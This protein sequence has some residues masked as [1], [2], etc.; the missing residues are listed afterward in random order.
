MWLASLGVSEC[1]AQRA[2]RPAASKPKP[3]LANL[4]YGP[5]PRNVLDLWRASSDRPT[6]L[7]VF[8]HGGGFR[9]GSKDEKLPPLLLEGCLK[10]GISVMAINYRLTP[11]VV[12]PAHYLDCARAIQFARLHAREWNLD[13]SRIAASGGSAGAITSLWLGFHDDMADPTSPDPVLRQSTRLTCM[14]VMYAQS[15]FDPRTIREWIG[16]AAAQDPVL[17]SFYGLKDEEVNTP[18]AFQLY[19]AAAPINRL[20]KD[21]PPVYA[22]YL[23]ARGPLPPNAKPGQGIHHI[24]FGLRLK[25]KMDHLGIECIV[26]HRDEGAASEQE[27]VEFLKRHLKPANSASARTAPA[28]PAVELS[29]AGQARLPV[30]IA[31]DASPEVKA[32]ATELTAGL[33]RITGAE[34]S[35]VTGPAAG[36]VF[37]TDA[38]WP[39]KLPAPPSGRSAVLARDDYILRTEPGRV[40][41]IGRTPLGLRNAL[42][43]FFHRAGFRHYFPGPN[44]EIW[45]SVPRLSVALD[46]FETPAYYTRNLFVGGSQAELPRAAF[47]Q[48]KIRNRM[49]PGFKLRTQHSYEAI[50][51]RNRE[52]FAAHPEA[53]VGPSGK[54]RKFDPSHP[55]LLEML[56][57]DAIEEF[58][59]NPNWDCISRDP[60]D[61]GGWRK[62]SPL[63][64]PTNQAL[65]ISNHVARAVQAEF[66]GRRVG[67]YAYGEHSPPPDFA[68]DP[69]VIVSVATHFLR[70]GHTVE[71]LLAEWHAKGAEMGIREYF[72]VWQW[73]HDIP[74]RSRAARLEAIARS[75]PHYHALGARYWTAETS[76]GWGAHGLGN[77]LAARILWNLDEASRVPAILEDFYA[78]SFGN[79]APEMKAYFERCILAS[80]N[81][82]MSEDLLGRMYRTLQ[83]ALAKAESPEVRARLRDLVLYTRFAELVFAYES[84]GG[85]AHVRAYREVADFGYRILDTN[86]ATSFGVLRSEPTRYKTLKS[87]VV[88]DDES[89]VASPRVEEK[90]TPNEVEAL[91][92]QGIAR[93]ALTP[94]EPVAFSRQLAPAG[95]ARDGEAPGPIKVRGTTNLY[96]SAAKEGDVFEFTVRGGVIYGDR[97][98]VRLRLFADRNTLTETPV[99]SASVPNDKKDHVIEL[100]SPHAG[101][102]RLEI[103][104]GG[105]VTLVSWPAGRPVAIPASPAERTQLHGNH[106]LVFFV[107]AGTKSIGGYTEHTKGS[108]RSASGEVIFDFT[109]LKQAGYFSVPV[110]EKWAGQWWRLVDGS[111]T[112]FS[113]LLMTVPPYF[114]RSPDELL[115]PEETLRGRGGR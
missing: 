55:A 17:K 6:P 99:S 79:V 86:M 83:Q 85:A 58:R 71:K 30:V 23:E 112:K 110:P 8:I 12:F 111:G 60:S 102:H 42:W 54:N 78:R 105:D 76:Q 80:G 27:M 100:K 115:L 109:S 89:G 9:S 52:F 15:T 32:L 31:R 106:T 62:D 29:A 33:R 5:H 36:I 87:P 72:G 4:S 2:E 103:A 25:E 97:G 67:M 77:Y 40:W 48:W 104:D 93:N 37:G 84:T 49:D 14:A 68:V 20:T 22:F 101:M 16:E 64:S 11:E 38:E 1:W 113:P 81:P 95:L 108:L 3:D 47:T 59:Q 61:G 24:T 114:A 41:L 10:A 65:T 94:F 74:G 28:A 21:D 96:L 57:R 18:R 75:I 92:R 69:H 50:L 90:V 7:L 91:L 43:D 53:L 35:V 51:A 66:P 56:A 13:P 44:W 73:D 26:R 45:P 107:P 88:W 98:A 46:A 34:F 39:G 70:Q 63:G 82:L 19:E